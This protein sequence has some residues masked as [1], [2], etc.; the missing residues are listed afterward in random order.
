MEL[1]GLALGSRRDTDNDE[2]IAL[3]RR[4]DELGYDT[5]WA[6]ESWGRDVF[7]VLT[8]LACHTHRIR[9]G[10][11]I[12]TVYSRTPAL[13]AQSIASL[14]MVSNGRAVLGLGTSGRAVVENWHGVEYKHPLARTREY[15][16]IIRTALSV[17]RLDHDGREF[18]LR[19]FRLSFSPVQERIPVFVASLG[20]KNLALT[21]EL[22]DGWLPIWVHPDH[23]PSMIA[24]VNAG[25]TTAGRDIADICVAPQVLCCATKSAEETAEARSMLKAHMAFYIAG[26]GA[27]YRRLFQRYGY[28]DECGRIQ[29]AWSR[30][31]RKEAASLVSEEMLDK[32]TV[33]GDAEECREGLKRLR[34][35]GADMPVVAFPHGCPD[36][37][38]MHTLEALAPGG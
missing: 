24:E 11:G 25:A 7:T 26:M 1:T 5:I 9:V 19:G 15:I 8:M 12:T 10:T 38:I 17:Q 33:Y 22:A 31:D 30:G 14:D 29:E 23:L 20:P 16:E 36:S 21:G 28:A 37:T 2:I 3:A 18:K 13:I 35:R 6:G 32:I 4:A 34:E 27:Y